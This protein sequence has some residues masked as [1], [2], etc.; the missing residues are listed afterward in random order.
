[1]Y[2]LNWTTEQ[3]WALSAAP[4]HAQAA[5]AYIH[6][7]QSTT[8]SLSTVLAVLWLA[9]ASHERSSASR[10]GWGLATRTLLTS[11]EAASKTPQPCHLEALPPGLICLDTW[12]RSGS[13]RHAPAP[14]ISGGMPV[15]SAAARATKVLQGE[16]VA[17]H[18][19]SSCS[20]WGVLATGPSGARQHAAHHVMHDLSGSVG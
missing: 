2:Q 4:A 19:I 10:H 20:A 17:E 8:Q 9:A 5:H 13:Y 14:S 16:G 12:L 6:H 11:S 7:T 15:S 18:S 3:Q 1:V